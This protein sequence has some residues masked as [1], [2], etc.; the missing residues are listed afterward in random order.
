MLKPH[1]LDRPDK[2]THNDF[3]WAV[4]DWIAARALASEWSFGNGPRHKRAFM[5]AFDLL[6]LDGNWRR[7]P[8]EGAHWM[9]GCRV[10]K[11]DSDLHPLGLLA[12]SARDRL[13]R[14]GESGFAGKEFQ[15]I[16]FAAA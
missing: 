12:M 9:I 2:L 4:R 5:Y 3:L 1:R 10:A 13:L 11:V 6:E 15:W 16:Y 8:L 14:R 7:E